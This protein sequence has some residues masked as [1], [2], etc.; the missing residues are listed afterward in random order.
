[1]LPDAPPRRPWRRRSTVAVLVLLVLVVALLGGA[2]WY[3]AGEIHAGALAVDRTPPETVDDTVVEAVDGDRAVLRR[4]G[5]AGEDDPLRRPETFGLVW[6][7]GAG[8]VSGPPEPRDDGS[9]VRSLEVIDGGVPAAGTPADLRGDVWTDPRMAHGV[10]FEDVDIPCLDGACPAWFVP[11][12]GPTWMVFVH[13]KGGSRTEGLRALGPAVDA[14]LPS[15]LISYRND[16]GAPADPSG[17]YRYGDTE[18]RDLEAAVEYAVDGGAEHVVLFGAS[19]GGGIVAAFLERSDRA[20]VVA[21]IVLD[22]PMLDLDATV[23][24]GAAQRELPVVG[25]L[26]DGLTSVAEWIAGRRFDLDWAAVDHLPG[27]WLEVPAL[28]FHGTDD[29]LVPISI[30]DEFAA[31]RPDLVQ[32][33]RV[34]DAGHV[35]SWN[36]DPRGYERRE[37]AFLACVSAAE[38]PLSCATD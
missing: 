19:M 35:R 16:E 27:D 22:A 25:A 15:L 24:H 20:D 33:V 18:W 26:P 28:V 32:A 3:Y 9:V 29:D 10:T 30:T 12:E 8:V 31:G 6:D 1:V 11:G 7:G 17:E 38:P 2:G 13:G 4:T 5:E 23:D 14:G 37:S 34:E 36:V 21:G